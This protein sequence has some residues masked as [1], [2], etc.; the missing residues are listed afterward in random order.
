MPTLIFVEMPRLNAQTSLPGWHI[1]PDIPL[2][3][4]LCLDEGF[5]H[6]NIEPSLERLI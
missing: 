1:H 3:P 5:D 4:D 2:F 6:N